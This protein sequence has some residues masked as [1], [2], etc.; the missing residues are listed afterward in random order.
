MSF[1][2]VQWWLN[3]LQLVISEHL[4]ERNSS[5]G[6]EFQGSKHNQRITVCEY[7]SVFKHGGQDNHCDSELYKGGDKPSQP[8]NSVTEAHHLH[9]LQQQQQT[10]L[11][12]YS[13]AF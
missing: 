13:R 7:T 1:L 5:Y 6:E 8:V 10:Y 11:G 4:P 2:V 3:L 12:E 9:H